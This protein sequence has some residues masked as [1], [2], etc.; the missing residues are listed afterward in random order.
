MLIVNYHSGGLTAQRREDW[1]QTMPQCLSLSVVL[2]L[3]MLAESKIIRK[4]FTSLSLQPY[5]SP[6]E[7]NHPH[8]SV[9]PTE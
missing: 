1:A 6:A 2:T 3:N 4:Y 8:R 9:P 7:R 5:L